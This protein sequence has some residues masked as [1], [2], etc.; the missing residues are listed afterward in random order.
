MSVS[1]SL[2]CP[3]GVRGKVPSAA[4]TPQ[5]VALAPGKLLLNEKFRRHVAH[6]YV[7]ARLMRYIRPRF[8]RGGPGKPSVRRKRGYRCW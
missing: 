3:S 1:L 5:E 8:T 2:C 6:H 4:F 7:V